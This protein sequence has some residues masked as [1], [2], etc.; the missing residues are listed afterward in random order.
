VAAEALMLPYP[1]PRVFSRT[2]CERVGSSCLHDRRG[3]AGQLRLQ[4]LDRQRRPAFCHWLRG[5]RAFEDLDDGVGPESKSP[6]RACNPP[7]PPGGAPPPCVPPPASPARWSAVL[8]TST[9]PHPPTQALRSM[10]DARTEGRRRRVGRSVV[11]GG[12]STCTPQRRGK[13]VCRPR[14]SNLFKVFILTPGDT[15][16]TFS[17]K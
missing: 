11:D 1:T 10:D 17:Q 16:P 15:R 9:T 4:L 6:P 5:L 12:S 8:R 7:P 14:W 2:Q 3:G 13:A